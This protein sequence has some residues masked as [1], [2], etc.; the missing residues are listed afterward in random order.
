MWE[1]KQQLSGQQSMLAKQELA[2]GFT[3]EERAAESFE[4]EARV[5]TKVISGL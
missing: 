1:Q 3:A 5:Q 2:K 4:R